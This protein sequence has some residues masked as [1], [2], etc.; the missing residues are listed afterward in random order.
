MPQTQAQPSGT[1]DFGPL[2]KVKGLKINGQYAT[3][4]QAR[5]WLIRNRMSL[6]AETRPAPPTTG[7][8]AFAE[9][10][11]G[12][13]ASGLGEVSSPETV[14]LNM[15]LGLADA[16]KRLGKRVAQQYRGGQYGN[17]IFSA[18]AMNPFSANTIADMAEAEDEGRTAAA[19]GIGAFDVLTLLPG[20][21]TEGRFAPNT[22]DTLKSLADRTRSTIGMNVPLRV[23]PISRE[24]AYITRAIDPEDIKNVE[25]VIPELNAAARSKGRP[26][27]VPALQQTITE[28]K[29]SLDNQFNLLLNPLRGTRLIPYDIAIALEREAKKPN[30]LMTPEGL[31]DKTKLEHAALH[32]QV[33][34]SL[35]AL[36]EERITYSSGRQRF[37]SKTKEQ[38]GAA[39]RSSVDEKIDSIVE[40]GLKNYVYDTLEKH[41]KGTPNEGR[42]RLMKQKQS[43]LMTLESEAKEAATK[44]RTSQGFRKGSSLTEKIKASVYGHPSGKPGV[45]FHGLQGALDSGAATSANKAV[46]KAFPSPL[47]KLARG[48]RRAAAVSLPLMPKDREKALKLQLEVAKGVSKEWADRIQKLLDGIRGGAQ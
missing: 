8:T 44:Q 17:M 26:N 13:A 5:E 43:A 28:A 7:P 29:T 19:R 15:V 39:L 24:A 22:V 42:I 34:W 18:L 38:Q 3:E 33:P 6:V 12:M 27:T 11:G 20:L 10:M 35:E 32:Y 2:G 14:P 36:N 16:E 37:F 40:K 9:R 1:Y 41:Y 47:R 30:L 4:Q 23:P 25:K 31:A 46:N 21:R 45:S 48:T